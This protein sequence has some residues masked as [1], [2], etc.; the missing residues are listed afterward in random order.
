VLVRE[1]GGVDQPQVSGAAKLRQD[2]EVA[3]K[4]EKGGVAS[5]N[6]SGVPALEDP[7]AQTTAK[8]ERGES[9]P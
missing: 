8:G 5:L 6:G 9:K 1:A 7:K 3:S 2:A 4:C